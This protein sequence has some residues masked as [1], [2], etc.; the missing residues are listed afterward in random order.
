MTIGFYIY[1][2]VSIVFI[3][4]LIPWAFI[5]SQGEGEGRRRR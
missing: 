4:I 5:R 2:I 3:S 1:G